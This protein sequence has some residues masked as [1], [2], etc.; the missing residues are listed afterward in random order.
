M[1]SKE[2]GDWWDNS[3]QR[4]EAMGNDIT[5]GMFRA[6]FFYR[7]FLEDVRGKKEI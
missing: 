7:Y 5:W 1:L 3:R 4:L 2:A 6:E